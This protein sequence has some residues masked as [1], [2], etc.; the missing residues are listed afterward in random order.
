[1]EEFDE[2]PEFVVQGYQ[3]EPLSVN[4]TVE[5]SSEDSIDEDDVDD[6]SACNKHWLV[7][8]V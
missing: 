7:K 1:M 6:Q 2:V 5:S 8:Y 3:F 4:Q